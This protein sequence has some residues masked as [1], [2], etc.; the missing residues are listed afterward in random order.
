MTFSQ[1]LLQLNPFS[2]FTP[3]QDNHQELFRGQS[4]LFA[5]SKTLP[6]AGWEA[7]RTLQSSFAAASIASPSFGTAQGWHGSCSGP[8]MLSEQVQSCQHSAHGDGRGPAHKPPHWRR[9]KSICIPVGRDPA[10]PTLPI[11]PYPRHSQ[12]RPESKAGQGSAE[13]AVP[14][15]RG[16]SAHWG[17]G[18]CCLNPKPTRRSSVCPQ[19]S[20]TLLTQGYKMFLFRS[21]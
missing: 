2:G 19:P 14:R 17:R 16:V 7:D 18:C 12:N 20:F 13:L 8:P 15:A 4:L 5:S 1:A 6:V 3:A 21:F 9:C 11:A 10:E